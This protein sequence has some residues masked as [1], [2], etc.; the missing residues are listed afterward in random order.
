MPPTRRLLHLVAGALAA[1]SALLATGAASH[2]QSTSLGAGGEYFPVTPTRVFDARVGANSTT[3]VDV[4]VR[5]AGIDRDDILAVAVNITLADARGTGYLSA[6]ASGAAGPGAPGASLLNFNRP[7]DVVPNLG[8]IGVD[9]ARLDVRLVTN[10]GG[11][12]RLVVDV[13]GYVTTS[14]HTA[15]RGARL[16]S[17]EPTRVLDTRTSSPL[18]PRSNRSVQVAGRAGVSPDATAVV[19]NITGINSRAD[20]AD[21]YLTA[22]AAPVPV[23]AT[24][25]SSNGN[26]RPGA[27][28]ASLA[29]VELDSSGRIHLYNRAGRLHV[30]VDVVGSLEPRADETTAGRIIA[31]EEPFRTM[32]TRAEAFDA[33]KLGDQQ[34]EDLRFDDFADSISLNGRPVG[35]QSSLLANVTAVAHTQA[36]ASDPPTTYLS[37][38]PAHAGGGHPAGEA[39]VSNINVVAGRTI[40][41]AAVATYGA[42]S[43][44][45]EVVSVFNRRGATHY[46]IDAYAVILD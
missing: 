27:I 35:A 25:G 2:A 45:A 20:A 34:W 22:S 10:A 33:V 16:D 28:V 36:R 30:A 42:T 43:R 13:V 18:G 12:S 8:I 32:D 5:D 4:W 19:V 17:L 11:T 37:L 14:S 3:A 26:Y 29:I 23:G 46:I 39:D 1:I 38:T 41:N 7:G 21:T 31:L 9:D 15:G 6:A 44:G 40:A 24:P